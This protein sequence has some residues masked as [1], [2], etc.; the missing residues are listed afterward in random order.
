[1][2]GKDEGG[3]TGATGRAPDDLPRAEE[4]IAGVY[5]Q[6]CAVRE[7]GRHPSAIVMPPALYQVV[8]RYRSL[9]GDVPEGLPDYLGKYDL[10]GVPIYT[11]GGE[12]IVIR[13]SRSPE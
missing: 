5:A 2:R 8:Q 10:F 7:R 9:L 11:D 13:T 12:T 3:E 4:I 6:L 1:M